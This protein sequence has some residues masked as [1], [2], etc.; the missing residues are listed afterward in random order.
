MAVAGNRVPHWPPTWNKAV[1]GNE[2]AGCQPQRFRFP[3]GQIRI[4]PWNAFWSDYF[5]I[6]DFKAKTT[7]MK[8]V[9]F[10]LFLVPGLAC[11]SQNLQLHY[12][13]RHSVDPRLNPVNYPTV[14]FEYYKNIDTLGRGAFMLQFQTAMSGKHHNIGQFYTQISQSMR[15]WEPK[16]SVYLTYSGGLGIASGIYG[17]YIANSFGI[18]T[19]WTIARKNTWIVPGLCF[20]INVF[21]SPSYD[22][23]L[24]LYFGHGF[25]NYRVF[26]S[27]S[28]TFWTENRNHGDEMTAGLTGKKF[29]FV[30]NPQIW[31][32]V[33]NKFWLGSKIN[34]Y[35]N[36]LAENQFQ[37]YPTLGS[38]LEF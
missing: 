21:D 37:F 11:F 24:T 1:Y 25:F 27:G 35:Y 13:L 14:N 7:V 38:K 28:F 36:L 31:L 8:F 17:Y 5:R 9:F 20:R 3:E 6:F 29:A 30:G 12:D 15:F 26:T 33:K 34:V 18:G 23:Q 22:P 32:K 2:K 16:V 10:A 4:K 19:S